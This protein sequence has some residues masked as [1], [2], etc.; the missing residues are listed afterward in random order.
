[1]GMFD[2]DRCSRNVIAAL[3]AQ[4]RLCRLSALE[5][6]INAHLAGCCSLAEFQE[7][8]YQII[9]AGLVGQLGHWLGRWEY[10]C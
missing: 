6:E 1:M 3:P 7:R 10:D 5:A 9:E 2:P 8:L 4:D